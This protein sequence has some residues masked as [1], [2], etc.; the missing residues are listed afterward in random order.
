MLPETSRSF[1]AGR[2][3]SVEPSLGKFI[4]LLFDKY[5]Y[6]MALGIPPTNC[7]SYL[8]V[9]HLKYIRVRNKKWKYI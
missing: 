8:V 1:K 3:K 4:I 5:K 2:C 9:M 6:S 7:K